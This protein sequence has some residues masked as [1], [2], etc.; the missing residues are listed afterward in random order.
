MV[1]LPQLPPI[2][3]TA[4]PCRSHEAH[5]HAVIRAALDLRHCAATQAL[6]LVTTSA[7]RP[8]R[9]RWSVSC[10]DIDVVFEWF[11][12]RSYSDPVSVAAF[13]PRSPALDLSLAARF[14]AVRRSGGDS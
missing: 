2:R 8:N 9:R 5:A 11:E 6:V 10:D 4:R 3:V 12:A 14:Q 13:P 1:V 7:T